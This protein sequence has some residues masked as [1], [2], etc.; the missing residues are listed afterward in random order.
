MALNIKN[1]T[2]I[3]PSI[4]MCDYGDQVFHRR[5]YHFNSFV[6]LPHSLTLVHFDYVSNPR[7]GFPKAI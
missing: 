5:D 4:K 6:I 2:F 3:F 7:N 1:Q